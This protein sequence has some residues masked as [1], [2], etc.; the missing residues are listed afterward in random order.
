MKKILLC[1]LLFLAG[2]VAVLYRSDLSV[3]ELAMRYATPDSRFM[4]L[5]SMRVHY[6]IEGN[7][8]D[9]VPLVLLHGTGSMLQTW[10]GWVKVLGPERR[11]IRLDLPGYALTGPHP[12]NRAT[13]IYYADFLHRFLNRLGVNRCDLAG[14][15]LGGNIAWHLTL[16]HP[17]QVRSL[18]LIDAAGYPFTPKSVPFGFKLARLRG[19]GGL[20]ANLTPDALFRSSLENVYFADSLVTDPLVHTYA[21]L[22]R[23]TGNRKNFVQRQPVLDSLWQRIR[24]IRQPTLI[25][26]GQHDNLIPTTVADRFHRDLPNDTLIMYPNA[27]HV[28]MEEIPR[29]TAHDYWRWTAR[30]FSTPKAPLASTAITGRGRAE[31]GR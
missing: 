15:S 28:P 24:Q 2:L 21:D 5:D 11:I 26:W 14:N 13:S 6:R 30:L 4:D 8:N 10:D 27:G 1:L 3:E 22:N 16:I 20:V 17:V 9:T 29:Q 25:M 23:R 18:V 19:I 7:A 31:T 12:Q